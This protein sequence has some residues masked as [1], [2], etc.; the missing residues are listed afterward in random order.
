MKQDEIFQSLTRNAF[1]FLKR[2]IDEFDQAPKY[3][4]I[5][6]CAAVEM[7]LKARLMKEH[8]SLVVSKPEQA[9]LTKFMAGDFMSVTMDEARARIRDIVG[10][11]VADDAFN[12]FRTLANHRNKMIHFF[13]AD[14]DGDDKAKAQIVAEHCRSWFHLHRL[15]SR[16][17]AYFSDFRKEI[18]NADRSMKKH[19]KYLSAKLKELK[20]TLDASRKTGKTPIACSACGFKAAVPAALDAQIA[21]V[22]CLVCDHTETRV[23]I[24]CPHCNQAV[25]VAGEGYAAC[26]HCGKSIEPEHIAD[27]LT[28]HAAA[29]AAIGDGDD[30]WRPANCGSC[31]GYQTVVKRG[32][33]Y[34]CATC[35]DISDHVEQCDWCGDW[36]TGDMDLSH[37]SGC[38]HCEGQW[39][40]TKD[41]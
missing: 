31:D 5:H 39:G 35:F 18:A 24:D 23:E 20:P 40:H 17:D 25:V 3:S 27:A 36:N 9:S 41:D 4:V 32:D 7:L 30:R 33:A 16:W 34:F 12:S 2:G 1:D 19:R 28:D 22:R 15:L 10:E 13:H 26:K 14:V 21:T 8:W 11:E 29:H 6:F 38:G 37:S